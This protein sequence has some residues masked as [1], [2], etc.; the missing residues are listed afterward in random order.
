[1][2]MPTI[3]KKILTPISLVALVA[4]SCIVFGCGHPWLAGI[5][6]PRKVFKFPIRCDGKCPPS[7]ADDR[8][9]AGA[10]Y[11]QTIVLLLDQSG[12]N[13][14]MYLLGTIFVNKPYNVLHIKELRYEWEG[15]RGV[16]AKERSIRIAAD[17][18]TTKNGWYWYGWLGNFFECD[19]FK[20]N[21]EKLFVGKEP[22]DVF[23]LRLELEYS[24]DD[25]PENM[26]I[27]E[28]N[29]KVFKGEYISPFHGFG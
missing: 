1:M 19:F 18:Y 10:A 27:L 3:T 14:K 5:T 29:V 28:Y 13:T 23:K 22:G 11:P 12:M 4:I 16:F 6:Y 25:E 21:F 15:N 24:F 26:Q 7:S 2:Q 9:K 17:R 20:C 8:L